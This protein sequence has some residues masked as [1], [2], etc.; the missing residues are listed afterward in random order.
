L[1]PVLSEEAL[2]GKPPVAPTILRLTDY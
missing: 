2:A 1:Q